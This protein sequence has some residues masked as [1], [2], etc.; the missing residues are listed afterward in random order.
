VSAG[1]GLP[2]GASL[3]PDEVSPAEAKRR[4]AGGTLLL[5]DVR[6]GPEWD[7]VRI[8]G[9]VHLP[10]DQFEQRHDEIEP[11]PG[12]TVAFLCHHGRR[13]LTAAL[14]ARALGRPDLAGALSVLGGIDLWSRTADAS[15]PRYER[16]PGGM[17]L[18]PG[19]TQ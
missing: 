9:S 10:L 18:L 1:D 19:P 11:A 2:P 12:Q 17:R 14:A 15:V 8:D 3:R 5:V 7:L 4:L 6:T 16:G 13:S